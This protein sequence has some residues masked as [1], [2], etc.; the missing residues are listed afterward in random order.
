MSSSPTCTVEIQD[1]DSTT[2]ATLQHRAATAGVSL[3]DYVRNILTM[4]ASSPFTA[5]RKSIEEKATELSQR[6]PIDV[7]GDFDVVAAI[8]AGR[9]A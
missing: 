3:E 6:A 2:I 9:D 1:V 5:N 7:K 4:A 8:R